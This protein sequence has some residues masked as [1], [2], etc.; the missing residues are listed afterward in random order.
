ML[1]KS[2]QLIWKALP[3]LMCVCTVCDRERE[4]QRERG[5]IERELV[6]CLSLQGEQRGDYV[7]LLSC[8]LTFRMLLNFNRLSSGFTDYSYWGWIHYSGFTSHCVFTKITITPARFTHRCIYTCTYMHVCIYARSLQVLAHR[9]VK[10]NALVW[11]RH[12]CSNAF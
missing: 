6:C 1:F 4:T 2:H 12:Y 10:I 5:G 3:V 7:S 9:V 8:V 11:M